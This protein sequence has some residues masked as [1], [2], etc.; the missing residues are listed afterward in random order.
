MVY[1]RNPE[2]HK[3]DVDT[4]RKRYAARNRGILLEYLR[5][6]PCV[7]C[8]EDDVLVLEFDHVRGVKDRGL[9]LMARDG[10]NEEALR[11]EILKCAVRCVNCHMRKTAKHSGSWRSRLVR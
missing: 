9:F 3:K 4:N 11:A 1:R 8:G 2:R 10:A 5:G 7:D 6:H